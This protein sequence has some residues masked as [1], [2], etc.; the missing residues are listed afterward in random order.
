MNC[1]MTWRNNSKGG[2]KGHNNSAVLC[3]NSVWGVDACMLT[4]S[5]DLGP[6]K[7]VKVKV[8]VL[9]PIQQPGPYWDRSSALSLV[10]V[11]PTQR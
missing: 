9:H 2:G 10:G 3:N 4:I 1:S 7:L 11:E 6:A 5:P 8:G